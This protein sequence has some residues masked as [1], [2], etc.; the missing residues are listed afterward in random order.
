MARFCKLQIKLLNQVLCS[1]ISV[2]PYCLLA[3]DLSKI[4]S[5]GSKNKR[6]KGCQGYTFCKVKITPSSLVVTFLLLLLS[7]FATPWTAACQYPLLMGILQARLLGWVARPPPG[8]L[9]NPGIEP[10]SSTL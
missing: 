6:S 2:L 3:L 10:R 1:H 9:P 7:H 8:D 4:S 5:Y